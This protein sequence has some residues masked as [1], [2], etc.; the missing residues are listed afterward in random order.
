MKG[1]NRL[2]NNG[3]RGLKKKKKVELKE[4]IKVRNNK[5]PLHAAS[6]KVF[7]FV[8]KTK[9]GSLSPRASLQRNGWALIKG[10]L[11][12]QSLPTQSQGTLAW[13]SQNDSSLLYF[14]LTGIFLKFEDSLNDSLFDLYPKVRYWSR[15]QCT[16]GLKKWLPKLCFFTWF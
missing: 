6:P 15:K 16:N 7:I 4:K 12:T 13:L 2:K 9:R 8:I 5:S 1:K 10:Q 14:N 3:T 11:W